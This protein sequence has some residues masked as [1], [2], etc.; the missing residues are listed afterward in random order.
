MD[1]GQVVHDHHAHRAVG[2]DGT[3]GTSGGTRGVDDRGKI[4]RGD[5]GPS[6]KYSNRSVNEIIADK[7]PVSLELGGWALLVAL[8]LG[9]PLGIIAA[10]R[11][12]GIV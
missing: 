5:L 3:L 1:V 10:V 9:L 7:L 2:P 12:Q 11:R 4:V 8:S 6:F